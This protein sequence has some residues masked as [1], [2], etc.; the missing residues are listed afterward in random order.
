V[1]VPCI[2]PSEDPSDDFECAQGDA[3]DIGSNVGSDVASVQSTP[4]RSISIRQKRT[5]ASP[6]I[7]AKASEA[8]SAQKRKRGEPSPTTR[9]QK[10]VKKLKSANRD[11]ANKP[12]SAY[13]IEG[14]KSQWSEQT[15]YG[16]S[17]RGMTDLAQRAEVQRLNKGVAKGMKSM[18]KIKV[19]DANYKKQ[20]AEKLEAHLSAS[21]VSQVAMFHCPPAQRNVVLHDINFI[22]VGKWVEVDVDRT[23][24]YNSEGG[25]AVVIHVHDDLADVK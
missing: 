15:E 9:S 10:C 11:A 20:V 17:F 1:P 2:D 6:A 3:E 5:K 7:S 8:Q 19:L 14:R 23:P 21:R 16:L 22:S 18:M 4:S 25:I 13:T 12:M 24:G